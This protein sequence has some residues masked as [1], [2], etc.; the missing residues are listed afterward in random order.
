[1]N[2]YLYQEVKH[3]ALYGDHMSSILWA[4]SQSQSVR[5]WMN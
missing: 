1:M 2:I 3:A 4:R 5:I